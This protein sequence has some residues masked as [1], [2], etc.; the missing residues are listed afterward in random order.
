MKRLDA[1]IFGC[2]E[3]TEKFDKKGKPIVNNNELLGTLEVAQ[4]KANVYSSNPKKFIGYVQVGDND[5]LK[6]V[7]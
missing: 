2:V 4:K 3:Q 7:K 1:R 5:F 6:I